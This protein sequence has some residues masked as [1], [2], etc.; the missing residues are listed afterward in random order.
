MRD[1]ISP[2][3]TKVEI[4]AKTDRGKT[5]ISLETDHSVEKEINH[6][7]AEEIAIEI[8]DQIIEV[9]QEETIDMAIGETTIDMMIEEIVIDRMIGKAI[10][11]K[12]KDRTITETVIDQI[13]EETINRDIEI[14]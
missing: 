4:E 11:D 14:K 8:I 12:I 1:N 9:D 6:I 5:I 7:E 10:I 3:F 2:R 13:M